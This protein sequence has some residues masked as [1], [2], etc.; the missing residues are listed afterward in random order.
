MKKLLVRL[1][2]SWQLLCICV[3]AAVGQTVFDLVTDAS[4]LAVGQEVIIVNTDY[5]RTIKT[6]GNSTSRD[7]VTVQITNGTV[8]D[9]SSSA[10]VFTLEQQD[11]HWLLSTGS[12]YLY[13]SSNS[14]RQLKLGNPSYMDDAYAEITINAAG[15][16]IIVLSQN[17]NYNTIRYNRSSTSF[18][19]C[20]NQTEYYAV[21]L[22]RKRSESTGI[23]SLPAAD[24][25][26]GSTQ[27][28]AVFRLDGTPIAPANQSGTRGLLIVNRRIVLKK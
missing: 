13:A 26:A 6:S 7:A 11:G 14:S 15:E 21:S 3:P 19:C 4:T 5:N 23:E 2:L 18:V 28:S 16:A 25:N 10:Q 27:Q 17:F 12:A 22:F 1:A 24:G 8:T 9:L 20:K